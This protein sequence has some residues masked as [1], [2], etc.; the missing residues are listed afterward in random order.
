MIPRADLVGAGEWLDAFYRAPEGLQRPDGLWIGGHPDW[1]AVGAWLLDVYVTLREHGQSDQEAKAA[2]EAMI[3]LSEEWQ[4]KHAA[5]PRPPSEQPPDQTL[6]QMANIKGAMWTQRLKLPMGPYPDQPYNINA[7]DYYEVYGSD[8]RKRMIEKTLADGYTHA[9]TGPLYDEGGYHGK[10][11]PNTDLSQRK[12]DSYLDCMQEWRDAGLTPVHFVKPDNWSLE[13]VRSR[14][15]HL[16]RQERAKALLPVLVPGGWEPTR[17]GW[18]TRTWVG[19]A[20]WAADINPAALILAH[21]VED[22][23]ALKGSDAL[24]N[25]EPETNGQSWQFVAPHF[26]GWLIQLGGFV[27]IERRDPQRATK[28]AQWKQNLGAYFKDMRQRFH[29]G[30][31]GWPTGSRWGPTVPLKAYY[32]E[33]ASYAFFNDPAVTEAEVREFG[34]IA[35]RAGADGYLDGGSL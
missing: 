8:D 4:I 24:Y 23:D 31:A 14:L 5:A 20:E 15:E 3:R 6:E 33:G 12:W 30:K 17:Y 11:P 19:F 32:G 29:E 27:H 28:V 22:V 7:M 34:D 35:V 26:H 9:V 25:D 18:S 2:I 16:Y 21:T 10:W 1:E 13:N